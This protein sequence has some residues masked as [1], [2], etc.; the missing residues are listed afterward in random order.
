[1]SS[2]RA[3]EADA[4]ALSGRG[5]LGR[6]DEGRACQVRRWRQAHHGECIV[7]GCGVRCLVRIGRRRVGVDQQAW[8]VP[9]ADLGRMDHT[10]GPALAGFEAKTGVG[11]GGRPHAIN[12]SQA[13][14]GPQACTVATA[15]QTLAP[16]GEPRPYSTWHGRLR[17]LCRLLQRALTIRR[18]KQQATVRAGLS[19][20]HVAFGSCLGQ[21]GACP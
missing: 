1:M 2:L 19:D 9:G 7:N 8:L 13:L 17:L 6:T 4:V 18:N 20:V 21:V 12:R 5:E 3:G 16:L 11:V 10:V 15:R 14:Y